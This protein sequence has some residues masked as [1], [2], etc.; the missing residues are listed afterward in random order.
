MRIKDF[1]CVVFD[2]EALNNVFTCTLYNTETNMLTT[3]EV[4]ERRN[5]MKQLIN[6]FKDNSL[7]FVG[8]NNIHFDKVIINY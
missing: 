3:Y 1:T 7:I 5:E 4:S 6:Y 8:Y 2:V